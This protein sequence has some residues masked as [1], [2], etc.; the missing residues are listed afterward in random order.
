M[1]EGEQVLLVE[2]CI[3]ETKSLGGIVCRYSNHSLLSLTWLG[4]KTN[5]RD[6]HVN[7]RASFTKSY[8]GMEW[9]G[10]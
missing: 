10:I 9:Y 7:R 1:K 3:P 2:I 5:C 6:K 4:K 8:I